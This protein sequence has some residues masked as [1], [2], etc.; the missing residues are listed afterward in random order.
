MTPPILAVFTKNRLNPAYDAARSAADRVAAESGARTMHYVPATPDDVGEQKALVIEAL[1]AR[2]AGVVFNPTDD[3]LMAEDLGRFAA[4]GIPVAVFI[5]RMTG[6]ALTFVG[7]DDVAIGHAV[8]T[9]L[10]GGLGGKGRIVALDGTPTAPTARDRGKGLRQAVAEHP[11]IE[12]LGARVGYLQRAP[13]REAMAEL[14]AAYPK[15]DGVWT[16]NDMMAFGAVDALAAAGRRAEVVGVNGLPEAI[17]NIQS[18]TMLATAD[19]SALNIA[20]IATRAVLRH[21]DGKP[22]PKEIMV[23]AALIDRRNID[24]WTVP[25]ADR[26]CPGWGE[27]VR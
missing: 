21:L 5:N 22:V 27:I 15:I 23:P 24:Q 2:P 4:A 12:L 25:M 17:A 14:L 1:A 10:I 26:P 6:P 8:A 3:R 7:S 9:A 16:A 13:A 18:G 11:G 19:F 20:A